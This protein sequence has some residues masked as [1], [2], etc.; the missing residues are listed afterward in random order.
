MTTTSSIDDWLSLHRSAA[1]AVQP[2]YAQIQPGDLSRATPCAGWDLQQLLRHVVGQ[3]HGFAAAA[4]AEVGTEAF[5]P[6]ALG[7][8]LVATL[9]DSI[10][11]VQQSFAQADPDR[12]VLLPEFEMRRFSLV[13]VIGFHF[14]DTLVHGWDVASALGISVRYDPKLVAAAVQ[15]ARAVPDGS[16][17]DNPGAAFGRPLTGGDGA[18]PWRETL[19]WLGRD[20][21]WALPRK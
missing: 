13:A 16:S 7:P 12:S 11:A 4:R 15:Q 3:D 14:I 18:E 20:P 8:D 9:A 1:E 17:R 19:L 2:M 5:Q 21:E 6:R 10:S